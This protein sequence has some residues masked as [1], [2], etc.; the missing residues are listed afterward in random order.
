[1]SIYRTS[2]FNVALKMLIKI[3]SQLAH[4]EHESCLSLIAVMDMFTFCGL[5][6]SPHPIHVYGSIQANETCPDLDREISRDFN[7]ICNIFKKYLIISL[8]VYLK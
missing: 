2:G 6:W 4:S 8:H 7:K 3:A 1:M 5:D